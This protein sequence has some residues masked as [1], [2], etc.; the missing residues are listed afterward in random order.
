MGTTKNSEHK[1]D[2]KIKCIW[3]V[4]SDRDV[5]GLGAAKDN[6]EIFFMNMHPDMFKDS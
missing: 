6:F 2:L 4:K 5:E 1:N 3:K